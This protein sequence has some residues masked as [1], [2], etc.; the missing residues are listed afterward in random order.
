MPGLGVRERL[1][2]GR[3]EESL[4]VQVKRVPKGRAGPVS[5]FMDEGPVVGREGQVPV[6]HCQVAG[7]GVEQQLVALLRVLGILPKPLDILGAGGNLQHQFHLAIVVVDGRGVDDHRHP[8]AAAVTH[9]LPGLLGVG[10]SQGAAHRAAAGLAG[11]ALIDR[12]A[13]VAGVSP[14]QHAVGAA[15]RDHPGL[16]VVDGHE[17]RHLVEVA[18]AALHVSGDAADEGR[19]L[20]DDLLDDEGALGRK[21]LSEPLLEPAFDAHGLLAHAAA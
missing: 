19:N 2:E 13:A 7:H 20:V 10:R 8:G 3:G 17:I 11:L 4:I 16:A 12:P 18:H 5:E 1:V 14:E 6:Q 9:D 15:G 21:L